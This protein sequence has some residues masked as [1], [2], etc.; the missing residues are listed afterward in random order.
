MLYV[1]HCRDREGGAELRAAHNPAHAAY[2]CQHAPKVILGGPLM[3]EDGT[4]R[5]G[6]LVVADF[7]G[8]EAVQAFLD[9]EP[10]H[11]AGL[12]ASVSVTRFVAVDHQ[13]PEALKQVK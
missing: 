8:P 1:I 5:V 9:Q 3:G 10:Y 6:I 12:F 4:T 13:G 11:Q 2:M 7:D